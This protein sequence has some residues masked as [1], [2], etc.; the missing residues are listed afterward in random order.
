MGMVARL[1]SAGSHQIRL[2]GIAEPAMLYIG[3]WTSVG[4]VG[5]SLSNAHGRS[6]TKQCT[7]RNKHKKHCLSNDT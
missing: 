3:L 2:R 1:T 7:R 6:V 5:L 4:L